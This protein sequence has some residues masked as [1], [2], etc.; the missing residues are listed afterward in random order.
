[1]LSGG[2][3]GR[4]V[5]AGISGGNPFVGHRVEV[6]SEPNRARKAI[7]L[8]EDNPVGYFVKHLKP[9]SVTPEQLDDTQYWSIRALDRGCVVA[10]NGKQ[11]DRMAEHYHEYGILA[12]EL[13][14]L[15]YERDGT[16]RIAV[17]LRGAVAR[18]GMVAKDPDS[19]RAIV[20]TEDYRM[21]LGRAHILSTYMG[22][23]REITHPDIRQP[24]SLQKLIKALQV[25]DMSAKELADFFYKAMDPEYVICT[26]VALWDA[27]NGKWDF[28]E[29][30]LNSD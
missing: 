7:Q 13:G 4:S 17:M 2:Y 9:E 28:G 26:D 18:F 23:S 21:S 8:P 29:K 15:G 30:N 25:G 20:R 22:G 24:E 6:R 5:I 27:S 19:D 16:A 12:E 3:S 1:M 10:T 14:R 11:T